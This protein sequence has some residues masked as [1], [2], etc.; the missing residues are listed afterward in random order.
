[1]V[2]VVWWL[3]Q[4]MGGWV[5]RLCVLTSQDRSAWLRAF[6]SLNKGP[7]PTP[8]SSPHA[9]LKSQV[10]LPSPSTPLRSSFPLSESLV[11]CVCSGV[12]FSGLRGV[13]RSGE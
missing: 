4:T 8:A 9:W 12:V 5:Y 13:A 6:E 10:A 11:V 1:M 2:C 7:T 3:W